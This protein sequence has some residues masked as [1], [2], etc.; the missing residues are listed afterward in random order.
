MNNLTELFELKENILIK[1]LEDQE[2]LKAVL[3]T[4]STVEDPTICLYENI[5]P[6][7]HTIEDTLTEEKNFITLEYA[8]SGLIN[9]NFKNYSITF[10]II[11]HENLI[12]INYNNMTILRTD[13][14]A[15][16]IDDIFNNA[17]GFGIGKLKFAG[18][19][20]LIINDSFTGIQL[21]YNNLDFN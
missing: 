16:R 21:F 11:V 15:S 8:S 13:F 7:K 20:P 12:K 5:F 14:I 1:L 2:L 10:F 4:T 3:N 9:D 18:L 19:Q 6:Y 17:R